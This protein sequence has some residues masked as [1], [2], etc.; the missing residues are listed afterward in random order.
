MIRR[1][2]SAI[3][4]SLK[5][6]LW[7]ILTAAVGYISVYYANMALC[8]LFL[9][10]LVLPIISLVIVL[11]R[12][13]SM[14]L[15]V[16]AEDMTVN[17]NEEIES[18]IILY[19]LPFMSQPQ[20]N[21]KLRM[22]NLLTD[23]V[24]E[25]IVP[26]SRSFFQI[27]SVTE[28]HLKSDECGMIELSLAPS[29]LRDSLG[30]FSFKMFRKPRAITAIITVLPKISDIPVKISGTTANYF[31]NTEVYS[32]EKSGDDPSE[33]FD[34]REYRPGDKLRSVHWKQTARTGTMTVK[35]M[36]LPLESSAAIILNCTDDL[37]N[38][39]NFV[40]SLSLSLLN[41]ECRHKI[42]YRA[43]GDYKS[44]FISREDDLSVI[45]PTLLSSKPQL[46]IFDDV[47]ER[48][49]CEIAVGGDILVNS[50]LVGNVSDEYPPLIEVKEAEY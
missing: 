39:M 49:T 17:F 30:L 29:K 18:K 31:S 9:I 43:D 36:S 27:S 6:V 37:S 46:G 19:G 16:S 13:F 42:Y 34:V 1:F 11:L 21:C 24:Y 25:R 45:L 50:E 35:E 20:F 3:A 41:E 28:T 12:R 14:R 22:T 10:M 32:T 44:A 40:T 23:R 2:F 48:F 33:V 5:T 15:K 38:V 26:I 47:K 7:L 4:G 8:A